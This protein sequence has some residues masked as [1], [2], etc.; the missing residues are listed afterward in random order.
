MLHVYALVEEERFELPICEGGYAALTTEL[1]FRIAGWMPAGLLV[2]RRFRKVFVQAAVLA[3][4]RSVSFAKRIW[5]IVWVITMWLLV[6]PCA[7]S[8][9][10]L[11][12]V[13]LTGCLAQSPN[14]KH[15]NQDKQQSNQP[16]RKHQNTHHSHPLF[17]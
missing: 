8:R 5:I 1:L 4:L 2:K 15:K 9:L 10:F 3:F 6:F 7:L 14:Y 12:S 13:P 11:S 17:S 16:Q